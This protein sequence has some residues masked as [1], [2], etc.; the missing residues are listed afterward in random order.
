MSKHLECHQYEIKQENFESCNVTILGAAA[1]SEHCISCPYNTFNREASTSH[2][3]INGPQTLEDEVCTLQSPCTAQCKKLQI[4]NCLHLSV[5]EI[6][7]LLDQTDWD[8]LDKGEC[9]TPY[10]MRERGK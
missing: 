8:S 7:V 4:G 9:I 3:E 5:D 6:K 2:A 10:L 1:I